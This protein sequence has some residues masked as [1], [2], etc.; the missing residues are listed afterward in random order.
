MNDRLLPLVGAYNFRDLGGYPTTDGR[1]TRWGRLFRS[2]TLDELTAEDVA[3]L[4]QLGLASI[5]DLRTTSEVARAGRRVLEDEPIH[6]VH[7]SVIQEEGQETPSE[8]RAAVPQWG[9]SRAAQRYLWYLEVGAEPLVAAFELMAQPERY[10]LVFH[11]YAGKDRTGVL[12]ALVLGCL[13]VEETAIIEDYVLTETRME[14]IKSR[15]KR[16][17]RMGERKEQVPQDALSALA[18]TMEE[19]LDGLA[20]RYGGPRRWA[21]EAGVTESQLE[22]LEVALL[23]S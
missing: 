4:R 19:F 14:L 15:I 6:Y 12:A 21:L 20:V 17:P 1:Q 5:I 8:A 16:D 23:Q 10:P 22:A 11:C 3:A 9:S 7:L 13:G 18:E 2:D